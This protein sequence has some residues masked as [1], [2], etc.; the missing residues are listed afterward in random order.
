[1]FCVQNKPEKGSSPRSRLVS[2]LTNPDQDVATMTAEFLFVLCK[3]NVGKLVKHSGKLSIQTLVFQSKYT[4]NVKYI[5][6]IENT[7]FHIDK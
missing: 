7:D 1:M 5:I 3:H 6:I 2:L 4:K